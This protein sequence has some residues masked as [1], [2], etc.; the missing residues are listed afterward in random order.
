[1]VLVAL[2]ADFF[3]S[4]TQTSLRVKKAQM[5]VPAM[6]IGTLGLGLHVKNRRVS[7]AAQN[8]FH[9]AHAS[10]GD[11]DIPLESLSPEAL[12]GVIDDFIL[13]EGTDY[14]IAEATLTKKRQDVLRQLEKGKAKIVFD[15]ET[16]SITLV[17]LT[18]LKLS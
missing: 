11:M 1:V 3:F 2:V 14:G 18:G 8:A 17:A 10:I 16:E 15:A 7:A 6:K 13:R 9:G 12:Q 4:C 5:T